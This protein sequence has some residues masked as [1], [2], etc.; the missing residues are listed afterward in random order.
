[1]YVLHDSIIMVVINCGSSAT[2]I[3]IRDSLTFK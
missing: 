3:N 1:M 2:A